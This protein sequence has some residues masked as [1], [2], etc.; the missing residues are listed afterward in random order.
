MRQ[1]RYRDL[2]KGTYDSQNGYIYEPQVHTGSTGM[3][4][5]SLGE[6]VVSKELE[7]KNYHLY[8]NNAFTSAPL[9]TA[10]EESICLW[11]CPPELQGLSCPSEDDGNENR[12]QKQ[13]GLKTGMYDTVVTFHPPS[14][15]FQMRKTSERC[16]LSH[17]KALLGPL[18]PSI[19]QLHPECDW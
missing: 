16:S 14:F 5:H 7:E 12:E 1:V 11:H 2:K 15:L 6:R 8:F 17:D 13:L 9:L 10:A 18:N 3:K 4:V 19:L